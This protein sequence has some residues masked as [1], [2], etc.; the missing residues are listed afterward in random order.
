M[1]LLAPQRS[2]EGE[3]ELVRQGQEY[4]RRAFDSRFQKLLFAFFGLGGLA[5]VWVLVLL[6]GLPML[7]GWAK[8]MDGLL[9]FLG[10]CFFFYSVFRYGLPAARL[11]QSRVDAIQAFKRA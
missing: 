9:L 1:R 11:N 2:A 7:P 5:I 8:E 4:V 10:V 3:K 6:V